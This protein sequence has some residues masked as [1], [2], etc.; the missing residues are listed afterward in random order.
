MRVKEA[1]I[2]IFYVNFIWKTYW[3]DKMCDILYK[4]IS[5]N[6]KILYFEISNLLLLQ[7][8]V[9]CFKKCFTI[10]IIDIFHIF[11][12]FIINQIFLQ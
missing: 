5:N 8:F 12:Q 11:D 1:S 10:Y 9:K 7:N 4:N 2:P 6:M 3:F